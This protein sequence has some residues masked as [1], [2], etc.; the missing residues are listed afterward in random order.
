MLPCNKT[1]FESKAAQR[2]GINT[3][4]RVESVRILN[5]RFDACKCVWVHCYSGVSNGSATR[6][7]YVPKAIFRWPA[8]ANGGLRRLK[9]VLGAASCF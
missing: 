5:N 8:T 9:L 1:R 7:Q 4:K 6:V 3:T 2:N